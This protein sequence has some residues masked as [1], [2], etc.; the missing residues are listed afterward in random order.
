MRRI[1]E[2]IV[3]KNRQMF[4]QTAKHLVCFDDLLLLLDKGIDFV[5]RHN[6]TGV[7]LTYQTLVRLLAVRDAAQG[8]AASP[9]TD[10]FLTQL[11][12]ARPGKQSLMMREFLDHALSTLHES[13]ARPAAR[14]D[15]FKR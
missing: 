13:E 12:R 5:V 10:N 7:D 2:V 4:D 11:L 1:H 15:R 9:V 8:R 14:R 3:Y 6:D